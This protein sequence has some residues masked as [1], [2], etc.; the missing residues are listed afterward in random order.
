M[1]VCNIKCVVMYCCAGYRPFTHIC[2]IFDSLEGD[3]VW[4]STCGYQ[5]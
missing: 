3:I 5:T 4:R 1:K 2:G